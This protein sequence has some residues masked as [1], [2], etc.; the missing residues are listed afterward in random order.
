MTASTTSTS[1]HH[2][3]APSEVGWQFVS[4]VL[5]WMTLEKKLTPFAV[6]SILLIRAQTTSYVASLL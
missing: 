2:D 3:A 5:S 4:Y 1:I 6:Q